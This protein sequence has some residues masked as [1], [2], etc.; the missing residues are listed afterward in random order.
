MRSIFP[1]WWYFE[2]A[3]EFEKAY[4]ALPETPPPS[5]PR[6]FL[7]CH[8]IELALKTFLKFHGKSES[9]LKAIGH[10]LKKLLKRATKLGLTLTPET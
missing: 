7:L 9:D 10:D 8:M 3:M 1:I 6:Y 4:Y 2:R 5:W